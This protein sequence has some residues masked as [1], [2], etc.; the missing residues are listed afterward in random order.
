MQCDFR[1]AIWLWIPVQFPF[2]SSVCDVPESWTACS[3]VFGGTILTAAREIYFL[4]ISSFPSSKFSVETK[5]FVK[6]S[7]GLRSKKRQVACHGGDVVRLRCGI[8]GSPEATPTT[9]EGREEVNILSPSEPVIK[10]QDWAF[11]ETFKWG[12]CDK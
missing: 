2:P 10:T 1:F 11:G 9:E 12:V 7:G 3:G 6:K 5:E 4:K 8:D